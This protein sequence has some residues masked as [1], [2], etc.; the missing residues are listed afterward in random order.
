MDEAQFTETGEA[1]LDSG[2]DPV[3]NLKLTTLIFT[4]TRDF[5][6]KSFELNFVFVDTW[7]YYSIYVLKT[8]IRRVPS[9][10]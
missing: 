3:S 10:E 6:K 5:C 7:K 9:N 8:V 4:I 1:V 2:N